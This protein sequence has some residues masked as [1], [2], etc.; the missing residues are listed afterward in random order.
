MG[1][2]TALYQSWGWWY[3]CHSQA[4]E[5]RARPCSQVQSKEGRDQSWGHT[6]A[7]GL[8]PRTL[9]QSKMLCQLMSL[10]HWVLKQGSM[11]IV[12]FLWDKGLSLDDC[13]AHY[14][15]FLRHSR[16]HSQTLIKSLVFARHLMSRENKNDKRLVRFFPSKTSCMRETRWWSHQYW[17]FYS[18]DYQKNNS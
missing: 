4:R 1:Q 14:Y 11:G 12:Q 9:R 2:I 16:T 18:K 13:P 3:K 15:F 17:L 7:R 10:K 5:A 8:K 6:C